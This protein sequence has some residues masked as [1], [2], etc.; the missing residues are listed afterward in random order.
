MGPE[1]RNNR[2]KLRQGCA[3]YRS[4]GCASVSLTH[5]LPAQLPLTRLDKDAFQHKT[6]DWKDI[7]FTN[8]HDA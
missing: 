5:L 1:L 3:F 8:T 7:Y 2:A 4:V 6:S